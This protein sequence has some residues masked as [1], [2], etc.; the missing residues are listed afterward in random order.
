MKRALPLFLII[1]AAAVFLRFFNFTNRITVG[2]D[3][4]RD[5][6]VSLYGA[7]TI[8]LP[9]TGPFI[10]IAPVTTGP[11]YWIQLIFARF[12]MPTP[13][14]PWILLAIYSTFLIIIIYF[15]GLQ[16]EGKRLGLILAFLATFSANQIGTAVQLTNPSVIGF[17]TSIYVLLFIL[18]VKGNKKNLKLGLLIGIV[19]GLTIN[20]HYQAAGLVSLLVFLLFFGKKYL[21]TL[22]AA[23]AGIGLTFLPLLCF[24]LN[25]HW[26]NTRHMLQYILVDQYNIWTPMRWLT[27]ISDYWPNF[28]SYVLGGSITFGR[29]VLFLLSIGYLFLLWKGKLPKILLLLAFSFLI[30]VVIIRYYRGER[31]FGYLQFFHPYL[32]IFIGY[33][34][35]KIFS[36]QGGKIAGIAVLGVYFFFVFPS[37]RPRLQPEDLTLQTKNLAQKIYQTF[38]PG[39]YKLYKC[40][41]LVKPDIVALVLQLYMDNRYDSAGKPLI[42]DWGCSLP[43]IGESK[44]TQSVYPRIDNVV[45]ASI[46]SPAAILAKEW[47]EASPKSMYQSAARWWMDEQP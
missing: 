43:S 15:I 29:I 44:D 41:A 4:A 31:F 2:L 5:A 24:E 42:Y 17:Y 7:Q 13:Y 45:D 20:T 30:E 22:L 10:S 14:A 16:V 38:G 6:F 26:Y 37:I 23:G 18:L 33:L 3:S 21:K 11:W 28:L 47:V 35:N 9:I 19:L 25:N 12:I 32:F 36:L 8:Q 34:I 27:Y 40:R 39:P 46:A 1:F